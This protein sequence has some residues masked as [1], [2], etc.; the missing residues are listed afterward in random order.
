MVGGR[1][2]RWERLEGILGGHR[3]PGEARGDR[4]LT[5]RD[6]MLITY[7]DQIREP[8]VAPL[9]DAGGGGAALVARSRQRRAYPAVLS[10]FVRRWIF[11]VDYGA[12]DPAL[13]DWDDVRAM[14]ADFELMFDAVF[15]H[16]SVQSDWF[17][18]FLAGDPE[19]EDFFVTVEGDPDLSAVVRPRALPL[20]VQFKSV[21][22]GCGR[23]G[24]HS[25]RTRPT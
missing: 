5:E 14:A 8:G 21:R 17:S 1:A 2:G 10:V 18:R 25:A 9:A 7:G 15:N 22:E 19:F 3:L 24:R 20:F 4:P 6:A 12:V 13:G 16:M 23:C 11:G